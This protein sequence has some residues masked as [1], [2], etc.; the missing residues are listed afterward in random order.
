[1]IQA[2]ANDPDGFVSRVEF[3]QGSVKLGEATNA[4]FTLTWS[5]APLGV[6]V[7]TALAYDNWRGSHTSAAVT[8]SVSNALP[9]V[10]L[11]NPVSGASFF[12]D[13]NISLAASASD[14]DGTISKVEFFE[15]T[16]KLGELTNAPW[17]L[18]WSNVV[19]G[20]Y[21]LSAVATDNDGATNVASAVAINVVSNQPPTVSLLSP[22]DGQ[23]FYRPANIVFAAD[24]ND[25]DGFVSRVEFF[26]G[27]VKLGEA[28]NAP[29]TL[30]WTNA[31]LGVFVL[32]ALAYDNWRGSNSSAAVTVSISNAPPLVALTNP[33]SGALLF[34]GTNAS[35]AASVSDPDGTIS[36]VEFFEGTN[37]LGEITNAPWTLVWSNVVLGSYQL[38]AVATDNAGATNISSGVEI[39]V[40]SN[41]S[42]TVS[43]LSPTDGQVFFR[44]S[45]I[46]FEADA[47]DADGFISRVEFFQGGVKLG[48]ATNA[49]FTLTWSNAPLG[50]F[51]LTAFA[52]DNWRGSNSS[53]AVTVSV[54]NAPPLVALTNPVSGALFFEGTN[55]SLA[56]SASDPDGTI[57]KVEFFEGT[58]KLGE[59]TNAPWTLV[60]SNVVLGSY[61]LS[62][63]ATDNDGTTNISSEVA[64][65]VV[66]NQ[67]P[68]VTLLSPTDGQVF[69]RL[70][71]IVF[72][73]DANDADGFVSR[74]EFFQG[75][76][77]LGEATNA[78]FTLTWSNAPL[79]VFVLTALAYDNWRG[80]NS[81]APVTV[82]VSNAPPLVALTN[83][84][85]GALFFEGTNISLAA[86]A[87]DPDG[88]LSKVEFFEGTNK[89]G[90]LTNSPWT[91][92]WSNVVQGSY[93][94]S[95]VATD[96]DQTT[97]ISSAVAIAVVSNQPPTV[98]LL[99]PTNGQIFFRPG[100]I[101]FEADANDA[102]GL[103]SRVEFFQ[104]SVKLGEATNAPFTLIWSNP[105]LG[106]FVLSALAT[107]GIGAVGQSTT[108]S[109]Q[110]LRTPPVITLSNPIAVEGNFI[111][112]FSTQTDWSYRLECADS[113]DSVTW[114]V[115]TNIVGDGTF[116]YVT[117][118]ISSAS[119]K[120]YRVIAE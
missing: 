11:T 31:P 76:V 29:F 46:V 86:S 84:V 94:L 25:A 42:P 99:S 10:V 81:S 101:V 5:N 57:G 100:D 102:D 58:N 63:V 120:F 60:W 4:P 26:Q 49:P 12:E 24:A 17:M 69:Y 93:Q 13:T 9:L 45:N 112:S 3:F 54:S 18:V 52:Y 59:L 103:I 79:G 98:S 6:F 114:Q 96:N 77:K 23:V 40:V 83:P 50:V 47:N 113:P 21:Q 2:S 62:A 30:T 22:T 7:L 20:S 88:T 107:D 28:T 109:V 61:Q 67:P 65:A 75:G 36:K 82:S 39:T 66:S 53:F 51:V 74:V 8:M 38:S 72:T 48:E 73:A 106:V 78:P 56:A 14:P 55:I 85:S 87:S 89:L 97:N 119:R 33:V 68:T 16:N 105:P 32:T 104:G 118:N 34:E 70:S 115:L 64:I 71:N 117:N 43:L 41:Q 116:A 35:L 92:V 15:G 108:V 37:K 1:V 44:P 80:N 111:F 110:V 19:L 91:L 27:G 95:A 90:E